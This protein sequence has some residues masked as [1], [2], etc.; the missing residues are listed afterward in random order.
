MEIRLTART[1]D[2]LLT[3]GL[4]SVLSLPKAA[5]AGQAG[6]AGGERTEDSKT[7]SARPQPQAQIEG[8]PEPAVRKNF[9]ETWI[10]TDVVAK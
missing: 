4:R 3:Q 6:P 2:H 1:L 10:W 9:P 5:A 8:A 7:E